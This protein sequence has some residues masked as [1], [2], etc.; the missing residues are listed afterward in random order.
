MKK[1][2]LI[3]ILILCITG[4]TQET[5]IKEGMTAE[6]QFLAFLNT[7]I[8]DYEETYI[9]IEIYDD[10]EISRDAY[11]KVKN[12]RI[13]S[14]EEHLLIDYLDDSDDTECIKMYS[15]KNNW[16]SYVCTNLITGMQSSSSDETPFPFDSHWK[17]LALGALK[18]YDLD[19]QAFNGSLNRKCYTYSSYAYCFNEDGMLV[20]FFN[21]K[22]LKN[23]QTYI[24]GFE[25]DDETIANVP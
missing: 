17:S 3:L 22:K 21:T 7:E 10:G 12:G 18:E 14:Y 15:G 8:S 2:I 13:I 11:I 19:V 6:E 23:S 25:L 4:C 20:T 5:I 24:E 16:D 1:K 9:G